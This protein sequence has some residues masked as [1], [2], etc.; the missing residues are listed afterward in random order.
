MNLYKCVFI[1]IS[2][3][4]LFGFSQALSAVPS[5]RKVQTDCLKLWY[6]KPATGWMTEALPIGN[7]RI[8]AMIF[9][10]IEQDT[11]QFNDKTLWTGS[12]VS[13]GAFQN[14]GNIRIDFGT[15]GPVTSYQRSLDIEEAI[16]SVGY[17]Q[18]G[19]SYKREYLSSFPDDVI[20][21]RLSADKKGKINF[22]LSLEG[23]YPLMIKRN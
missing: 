16:A 6:T 1:C 13:R 5:G 19:V 10:G 2:F 23:G 7:G 12:T 4:V 17:Q 3:F 9:G 14:F 8:G 20:V 11:I 15:Q 22:S 18:E 21:I